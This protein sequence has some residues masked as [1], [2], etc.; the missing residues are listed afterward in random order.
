MHAAA[1]LGVIGL[2]ASARGLFKLPGMF[3]GEEVARPLAVV[4]QSIMAFAC[5]VYVAL[6]AASFIQAR[7]NR[8]AV[9]PQSRPPAEK[10]LKVSSRG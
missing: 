2:A 1:V 5:A 4:M 9:E 8:P 6:C 3:R 10:K 7:R